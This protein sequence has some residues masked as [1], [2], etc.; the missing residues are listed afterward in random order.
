[1]DSR[2][3][4]SAVPGTVTVADAFED[5][6]MD[7]SLWAAGGRQV[8]WTPADSGSWTW[9]QTESRDSGAPDGYLRIEAKGPASA[10]SYG[11]TPWLRS[12]YNFNDGCSHL[13]NFSWKADIV[14]SHAN[15]FFVQITDGDNLPTFAQE[16]WGDGAASSPT[17]SFLNRTIPGT[18]NLLW[19]NTGTEMSPGRYYSS[20]TAKQQW[21]MVI[22]ASGTARLYDGPDG[23]GSLLGESRLDAGRAWFPRFLVYDATSA[24]FPAGDARFN[25]YDFSATSYGT[26]EIHGMKW[27]DL[28]ADGVKDPDEPGLSGWTIYLDTNR[29]GQ[30]DAAEVSTETEVDGSYSFTQVPEGDYTVA[31]VLPPGWQQTSP[32]SDRGVELQVFHNPSPAYLDGFGTGISVVGNNILVGSYLDS[33]DA[34][35]AGMAYLFDPATGEVAATIHNPTPNVEDRFGLSSAA[36]GEDFVISAYWDDTGA[37]DAGAVHL[38]DGATG[39]LVWSFFGE[40]AGDHLGYNGLAATPDLVVVGAFANDTGASNAGAVYVLNAADGSLLTKIPNPDPRAGDGFGHSVAIVGDKILV[41]APW[42]DTD[43]ADGGAVYLFDTDGTLLKTFPNPLGAAGPGDLFGCS[44][45]I[46]GDRVLVGAEQAGSVGAAYEFD[47]TTGQLVTTLSNPRPHSNDRFGT[48]VAFLGN[49]VLVGAQYAN[50]VAGLGG[51]AYLFDGETGDLLK[52]YEKAAPQS[53]DLFG[54]PVVAYENSVLIGAAQDNLDGPWTG[55][56]YIFSGGDPIPRVVTLSEGQVVTGI[57]FGAHRPSVELGEP[58]AGQEGDVVTVDASGSQDAAG[59]ELT[60]EWDLNGD[61]LYD[62]ATGEIVDFDALDDG[63]YA[64]G[65]RVTDSMGAWATAETM[66]TVHNAAPEIVSVITTAPDCGSAAAGQAVDLV[67]TFVDPGMLDTHEAIIDWGDGR[68]TAGD[69]AEIGGS[70]VV[71]ASHAYAQ[72]GVYSVTVRVVDDDGGSTTRN[73]TVVIT[74][75]GIRDRVLYLVGTDGNDRVTVAP[76]GRTSVTV[77]ATFLPGAGFRC[78]ERFPI[79]AIDR[80]VAILGD[81]DDTMVISPLAAITATVDGG[82]GN[83]V[84]Q[85]GG[86]SN[87]LLGGAG[88]DV[89]FGGQRRDIL[90]GREGRD[91]LNGSGGD[92]ILVGGQT[93]LDPTTETDRLNFDRA[94]LDVLREWN[95]SACYVSRVGRLRGTVAAIEDDAVDHLLGGSGTD[96]FLASTSGLNRDRLVDR[97]ATETSTVFKLRIN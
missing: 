7:T 75:A 20:S 39:D 21:S 81:G 54:L 45:A 78:G 77:S 85:G 96:W 65:V 31:E 84:L 55:A 91:L 48:N 79:A 5:A 33:T 86:G 94:L 17:N 18:A 53:T 8:A 67:A 14:E 63:V 12:T 61:G 32:A 58:Y 69:I 23:S 30:L 22:E 60:Y 74:G 82:A 56:A 25:I 44:V 19:R 16:Y 62:D 73:S 88:N 87:I 26:G 40:A 59:H 57:D 51:A 97:L 47:A 41:A 24:G 72:G 46:Q 93:N 9:S 43:A 35:R 64:V 80:I 6:V 42:S 49:D 4:L 71:S 90:I 70:G 3:L 38:F 34:F 10:N 1:L 36:V 76:Y 13:I 95:S 2:C 83:D 11:A 37:T 28:N 68:V 66:V 27:S 92:D 29:N 52:T 50:A 89:L 15:R